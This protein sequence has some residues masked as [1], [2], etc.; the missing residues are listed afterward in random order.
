MIFLNIFLYIL[1]IEILL[2]KS[3]LKIVNFKN[4]INNMSLKIIKLIKLD[5]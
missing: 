1:K 2:F 4:I 3:I 5:N